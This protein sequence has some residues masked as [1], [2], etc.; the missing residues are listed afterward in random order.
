VEVEKMKKVLLLIL[1]GILGVTA[2]A[3]LVDDFSDT[4]LSEYTLTKVLDI[5]S[6][7]NVSFSSPSGELI[8]SSS[9]SDGPEQVLFLRDD[10]TLGVGEKLI[11]DVS[12]TGDGWDRDLGIAVCYTE[13]PPGLADGSSGDVRRSYVE[14]SARSNNQAMS[15]ALDGTTQ[16]GSGQDFPGI[17]D[18]IFIERISATEFRPGYIIGGSS[19]YIDDLTYTITSDP[20]GLAVGFYADVRADLAA[21]PAGLDNLSIIPEP[22]TLALLG[23]GGLL[24]RRKK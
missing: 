12:H 9:G 3:V 10:Y 19:T 23:L 1:A 17:V 21:S 18:Q 8:V 15:F 14:V 13:T 7:S 4:D 5:G 2:Q 16:L 6:I 22:A 20:V 11:A 24:L